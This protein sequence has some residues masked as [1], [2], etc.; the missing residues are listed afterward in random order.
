M[1]GGRVEGEGDIQSKHRLNR[2]H[3]CETSEETSAGGVVGALALALAISA[4]AIRA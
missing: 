4:V 3:E 1:G 2:N